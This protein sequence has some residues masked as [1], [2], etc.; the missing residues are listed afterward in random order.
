MIP[1]S[2]S[3]RRY[4]S[5]LLLIVDDDVA[6]RRSTAE[7]LRDEGY[8]VETAA[9]AP[10]ASEVL[11]REAVDLMLLDVRMPGLGGLEVVEVLRRRGS[12]I[13]ILM[14]SGYG[15]VETAVESLHLGADDFLTKPVDPEELS[16]RVAELLER[17][18]SPER[19]AAATNYGIVG[20]SAAMAELIDSVRQVAESDATVLVIGETGTGKE[21]V[22]RAI[23]SLSLRESGPFVPVN[24]AALAEGLLESELFGHVRGA[25]TG[26]TRDKDGLFAA[27][28]AGTLFLDEIGDMS[29][30]LQQRL[31]GV[32]QEREAM[33]VGATR[34]RPVDVRVVAATHRDLRE[35]M[36]GGRFRDDLFYRLNVFPIHIPPLRARKR[37]VSLLVHH[38][39][40]RLGERSAGGVPPAV[41]LPA[42]RALRAHDWPGN[43]RELMAAVESAA[44]RAGTSEIGLEHLPPEIRAD[45]TEG[46]RYHA[47]TRPDD[48]R[49]AIVAALEAAHGVRARAAELLGMSRTTLWR[50]MRALGLVD[51]DGD[52]NGNGDG[53]S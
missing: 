36:D 10:E 35:E 19:L 14:I 6:F 3:P 22:A 42:M 2:A 16:R 18:P 17:R 27:A 32:L 26:A 51:G 38:A 9:S 34:A 45:R 13:P 30:R 21:L 12:P 52:G 8:R 11:E 47:P 28:N 25:F 49:D 20:Q 7:L 39:L 23:H 4:D 53:E 5:S 50:R 1:A 37:D 29:L 48:E 41:S 31:L 46:G 33:P 15:D 40:R 44:I 24:C 43:V